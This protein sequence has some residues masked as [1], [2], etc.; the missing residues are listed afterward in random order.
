MVRVGSTSSGSA[1]ASSPVVRHGTRPRLRRGRGG[2]Q[3]CHSGGAPCGAGGSR[4]AT[5]QR[6]LRFAIGRT[7]HEPG[8][9]VA[10]TPQAE[11]GGL[12]DGIGKVRSA[13]E[14][15][16][17]LRGDAQPPGDVP[18]RPQLFAGHFTTVRQCTRVTPAGD[19]VNTD[20]SIPVRRRGAW[21]VAATGTATQVEATREGLLRRRSG[22]PRAA[23][24][25]FRRA[26]T[27]PQAWRLSPAS[28][29]GRRSVIQRKSRRRL[30]ALQ[31]HAMDLSV[32]R[33]RSNSPVR[34]SSSVVPSWSTCPAGAFR[35][36]D[37][38]LFRRVERP[39]YGA[40][41]TLITS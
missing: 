10:S 13:G 4:P 26:V 41:L 6:R 17:P 34:I 35:A 5:H 30:L 29:H 1:W 40:R 28:T 23:P 12:L 3:V 25:P 36:A 2:S 14:Q 33:R 7:V 27:G 11:V 31:R 15:P 22:G 18:G 24:P 32:P 37:T 9:H 16:C 19:G 39:L 38:R 20:Q 8:L 21:A